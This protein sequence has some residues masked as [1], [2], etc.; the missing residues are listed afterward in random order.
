MPPLGA[1]HVANRVLNLGDYVVMAAC[2]IGLVLRRKEPFPLLLLLIR[3]LLARPSGN[4][5]NSCCGAES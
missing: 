3:T 5:T 4:M 2:R 1:Y